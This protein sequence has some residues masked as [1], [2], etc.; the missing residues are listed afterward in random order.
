MIN[1]FFFNSIKNTL[2]QFFFIGLLIC[3]PLINLSAQNI[4]F[5][6]EE[7]I[8]ENIFNPDEVLPLDND[9]LLVIDNTV[10]FPIY[11]LDLRTKEII[12]QIKNGKGPGELSLM[13][14][15]VYRLN[16][17]LFVWDYGNQ[18]INIYDVGLTFLYTLTFSEFG[19]L[20]EVIPVSSTEFYFVTQKEELIRFIELTDPRSTKAK[21]ISRI[22]DLELFEQFENLSLRQAF[23]TDVR[24]KSVCFSN[25]FTSLVFCIVDR[26]IKSAT[27]KPDEIINY[28]YLEGSYG[29][30]LTRFP[31]VSLDIDRIGE[32]VAVLYKGKKADIGVLQ[33]EYNN[34]VDA[35]MSDFGHTNT[36][37]LYNTDLNYIKKLNLPEPLASI[38]YDGKK[39]LYGIS[40]FG[41]DVRVI[42]YEIKI[43]VKKTYKGDL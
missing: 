33:N 12:S 28:S 13:Y 34:D 42:K 39:G 20:Y 19:F 38:S 26:D 23:K 3:L 43:E 9:K 30:E 21:K 24:G 40:S 7:T 32:F 36:L 1:Y 4:E 41:G 18:R 2:N 6:Q 35:Y 37:Y 11:V 15:K 5:L 29:T 31:L 22:T 10:N 17:S 25:E 8:T 16:D 27:A 14:K